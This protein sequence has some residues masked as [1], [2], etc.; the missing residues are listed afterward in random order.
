[1]C[2][3][4]PNLRKQFHCFFMK[5]Q[6]AQIAY[7]FFLLRALLALEAAL[8]RHPIILLNIF[9][10][11]RQL[12]IDASRFAHLSLQ[13]RLHLRTTCVLTRIC[14]TLTYQYQRRRTE[15]PILISRNQNF[16]LKV[17]KRGQ[18][19]QL[20]ISKKNILNTSTTPSC[21]GPLRAQIFRKLCFYEQKQ[22][23]WPIIR[24]VCF[25]EQKQDFWPIRTR[26]DP[27]KGPPNSY[28]F[29]IFFQT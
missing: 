1:M 28:F 5:M 22:D 16:G 12:Q 19:W 6:C 14:A 4:N 3:I 7:S 17:S 18:I 26:F 25:Y 29:N 15:H 13:Q 24:K 20:S 27:L 8:C 11:S 21:G 9:V 23:F 2:A 10:T